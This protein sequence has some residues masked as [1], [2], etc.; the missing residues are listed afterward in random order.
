MGVCMVRN[1]SRD[2][3]GIAPVLIIVV[4]V[5]VLAAA[6]VGYFIYDRQKK[7]DLPANSSL[8]NQEASAIRDECK[9]VIDDENLCK[10]AVNWSGTK[11]YKMTIT[12]TSQEGPSTTTLE[13]DEQDNTSGV[14]SQDGKEVSAFITIGKT[15]YVKDLSDGGWFKYENNAETETTFEDLEFNFEKDLPEAERTQYKAEGKEACGNLECYKYQVIDP[16]SSDSTT[17]I[18]FDTKDFLLRRVSSTA[19]GSTSDITYSYEPVTITAPSPIKESPSVE[20]PSEAE[21]QQMIQDSLDAE[22]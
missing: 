13:T 5:A 21:I 6:G 3:R 17:T 4:I 2:S 7:D 9:S 16:K 11:S 19:A 14:V 1:L 10:F 22:Q 15:S 12:T 20:V 18:W 8:T